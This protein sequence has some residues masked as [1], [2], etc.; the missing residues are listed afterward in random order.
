MG[1]EKGEVASWLSYPE[2]SF[3]TCSGL[4]HPGI[5]KL[6]AYS[7]SQWSLPA[8]RWGNSTHRGTWPMAT[9]Y[10]SYQRPYHSSEFRISS[11]QCPKTWFYREK[12][13]MSLN[14]FH[15]ISAIKSIIL[16]HVNYLVHTRWR[17]NYLTNHR[18]VQIH[19][20]H[21]IPCIQWLLSSRLY[22]NDKIQ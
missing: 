21:C 7:F 14:V 10:S 12:K 9:G 19:W 13:Q 20:R 18:Y 3:S 1:K 16:V 8:F 22:I 6:Y 4:T 11:C 15:T 17:S 2:L 5:S